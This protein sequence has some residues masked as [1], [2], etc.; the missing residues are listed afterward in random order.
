M[1]KYIA[2]PVLFASFTFA[3]RAEYLW[4]N[5]LTPNGF[6]AR[7]LS[8]PIFV[9]IRVADDFALRTSFHISNFR[10]NVLEDDVWEDGGEITI[11]FYADAGDRPG[12]V[13]AAHTGEFDKRDTGDEYFGRRDYE[14]TIEGMDIFLDAGAYWVGIRNA[15][16]GGAG[17]NYWTTSD[18]GP[19]GKDS[20]TGYFSLDAGNTWSEEGAGWHHAFAIELIPEPSTWLLLA[21]GGLGIFRRRR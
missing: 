6:S 14:Y 21:L 4:D 1:C 3:V 12:A 19:D 9:D 15:L 7:A 18:G 20:S 17:T 13:V 5:G 2:F 11:E 8:P 16:G 10:A